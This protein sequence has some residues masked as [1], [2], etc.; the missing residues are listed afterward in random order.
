MHHRVRPLGECPS[1]VT[2]GTQKSGEWSRSEVDTEGSVK[3]L[4]ST[5][6]G[7]GVLIKMTVI[8]LR[9]SLSQL[10]QPEVVMLEQVVWA[11][12]IGSA[13]L[14]SLAVL[15]DKGTYGRAVHPNGFLDVSTGPS[16][17]GFKLQASSRN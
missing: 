5:V 13:Y 10:L 4:S 7:H 14:M 12:E 1:L 6:L 16:L 15:G 9:V 17:R 3:S 11:Y 2:T 8:E